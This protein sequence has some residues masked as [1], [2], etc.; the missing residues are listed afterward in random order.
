LPAR[1]SFK[2]TSYNFESKSIE[3]FILLLPTVLDLSST[4]SSTPAWTAVAEQ[5]PNGL[6]TLQDLKKHNGPEVPEE[7]AWIWGP[8]DEVVASSLLS[9]AFAL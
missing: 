9:S 2:Y 5:F 4:M 3:F 7:T 1:V 8:E 6:P